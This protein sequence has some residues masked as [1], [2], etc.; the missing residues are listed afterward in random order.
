MLCV[1]SAYLSPQRPLSFLKAETGSYSSRIPHAP[2]PPPYPA[3]SS[4]KSVGQ[5][6]PNDGVPREAALQDA[7]YF[8]PPCVCPGEWQTQ[9]SVLE[10]LWVEGRRKEHTGN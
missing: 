5:Q 1:F 3:Q 4:R 6:D 10:S 9:R 8:G 7:L 2:T